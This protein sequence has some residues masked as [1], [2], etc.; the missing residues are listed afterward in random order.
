MREFPAQLT[1]WILT[2]ENLVGGLILAR[3]AGAEGIKVAESVLSEYQVKAIRFGWNV[4]ELQ[5]S[6]EG[7]RPSELLEGVIDPELLRRARSA[8]QLVECDS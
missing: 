5:V 6:L 7:Q 1:E 8:L 3:E 4:W 2:H